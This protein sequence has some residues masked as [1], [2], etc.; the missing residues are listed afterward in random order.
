LRSGLFLGCNSA[1]C[2]I[3]G[4]SILSRDN[5]W[6]LGFENVEFLTLAFE[7]RTF[8]GLKISNCKILGSSISGQDIFL[9]SGFKN[10]E[11]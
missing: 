10:V 1:E 9:N 4:C 7:V 2:R 6:I 3:L 5:F 11:V 8:L